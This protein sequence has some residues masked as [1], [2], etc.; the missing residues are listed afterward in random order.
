MMMM[1]LHKLDF[2]TRIKQAGGFADKPVE[3]IDA[4][5]IIARPNN[6]NL[7]GGKFNN[8]PLVSIV[9]RRADNQSLARRRTRLS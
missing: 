9:T 1:H 5:R 8:R 6:R 4:D 7:L 3:H 2:K